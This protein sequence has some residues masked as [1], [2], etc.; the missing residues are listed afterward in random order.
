MVSK[1][2]DKLIEEA[3]SASV[4]RELCPAFKKLLKEKWHWE[5]K[6]D[7]KEKFEKRFTKIRKVGNRFEAYD[8]YKQREVILDP[9]NKAFVIV[10]ATGRPCGFLQGAVRASKNKYQ[11]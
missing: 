11:L 1:K 9:N 5:L 2:I 6:N 4:K 7:I 10:K 3:V 8:T